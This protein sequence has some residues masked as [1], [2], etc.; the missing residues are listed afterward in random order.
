MAGPEDKVKRQVTK[1]LKSFGE[2]CWYFMPVQTG[3]GRPGLDYHCCLCGVAFF[4]ETKAR[5]K[6]PTP[7]Q[8]NT[9]R[10]MRA[11]GSKVFVIDGPGGYGELILWMHNTQRDSGKDEYAPIEDI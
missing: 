1:I 10:E 4:V 8:E 9:I 11:A 5:G 6:K 2:D 3:F 7:R